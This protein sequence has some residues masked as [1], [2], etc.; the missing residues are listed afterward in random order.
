MPAFTWIST[1][2]AAEHVGARPV[3]CDI[4]LE[5]FNI[6][7]EQALSLI[8]PRTKAI[9][10]VHLFGLAADLTPLLAEARER[11]IAV[12]EDAACALGTTIGGRHVGNFGTLGC[13]SF[14]PRKSITTGEGGM[15]VTADEGLFRSLRRLRDI[16]SDR[17]GQTAADAALCLMP[18]FPV[19]GFN[20]RMSDLQ[21]ALGLSQMKKF[22]RILETRRACAR[23][24]DE[25]LAR[26]PLREAMAAPAASA[27]GEHSY[28]SYVVRL[29]PPGDDSATVG[30]WRSRRNRLM[31]ALAKRGIGTRPGT[32][33]PHLLS[34]YR[35]KY[36]FSPG[37]FPRAL[38]ADGLTLAVPLYA[39]MTRRD[40]ETVC[41]A[42]DECRAEIFENA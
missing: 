28:Q 23:S 26:S 42:L 14:H 18:D 33:A 30:E 31:G 2:N 3:F 24:Y 19:L 16:G 20:D 34:Y 29:T 13:F 21:A 7:V 40:L 15:I 10:P 4:D 25:W 39:R 1:P 12:V 11:G 32:H 9:I 17:D 41:E 22:P 5:S 6:D 27:E 35:E 8:T 38:R 36:G 37:D